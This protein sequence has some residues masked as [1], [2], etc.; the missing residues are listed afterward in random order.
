MIKA[1]AGLFVGLA[2]FTGLALFASPEQSFA[3]GV[4]FGFAGRGGF[5]LPGVARPRFIDHRFFLRGFARLGVVSG[6]IRI[7]LIPIIPI[8]LGRFVR[9]T[10]TIWRLLDRCISLGPSVCQCPVV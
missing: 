6:P 9:P 1:L 3:R 5:V 10:P 8:P 2:L 4:H 7:I